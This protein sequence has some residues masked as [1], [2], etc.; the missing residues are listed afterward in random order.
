[1]TLWAHDPN[2]YARR[3]VALSHGE[4]AKGF[5]EGEETYVGLLVD[6]AK[7]EVV[8]KVFVTVMYIRLSLPHQHQINDLLT[9]IPMLIQK[10]ITQLVHIFLDVLNASG[11]N[12]GIDKKN[13]SL[14]ISLTKQT[15]IH[16]H[17][18]V[19]DCHITLSIQPQLNLRALMRLYAWVLR[20]QSASLGN[21]Q[22][23]FVAISARIEKDIRYS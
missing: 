2:W 13:N 6:T 8:A 14:W 11:E 7:D 4:V 23:D 12:D 3:L 9:C 10:C 15:Q 16:L 17:K 22:D 5:E 19:D 1:M 20:S 21:D 18:I